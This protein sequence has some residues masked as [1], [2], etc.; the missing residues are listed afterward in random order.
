MTIEVSQQSPQ[1]TPLAAGTFALYD[2]GHGGFVLVTDMG[3]GPIR[4]HIPGTIV[5]LISRGGMMGKLF[6]NGMD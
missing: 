1:P 6:G 4:K 2:D 5:K 3:G